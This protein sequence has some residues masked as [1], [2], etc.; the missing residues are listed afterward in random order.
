MHML[1]LA[2][3]LFLNNPQYVPLQTWH[4]LARPKLARPKWVCWWHGEQP[5]CGTYGWHSSRKHAK[6]AGRRLC[7]STCGSASLEYCEKL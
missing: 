2:L 6:L 7:L 1:A 3:S 5:D 4:E